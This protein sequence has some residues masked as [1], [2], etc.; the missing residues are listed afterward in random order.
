MGS[1]FSMLGNIV[2][3]VIGGFVGSTVLR[4][5]GIYSYGTIGN[6]IVAV[7]GACICIAVMRMIK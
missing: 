6:I 7:I 3:G 1:R 5:V 2:M 4:F